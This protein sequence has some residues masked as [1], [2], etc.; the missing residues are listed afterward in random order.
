MMG[1]E[2]AV[3][4]CCFI[5]EDRFVLGV[6]FS[7]CLQTWD[8]ISVP[9]HVLFL[10]LL[11]LGRSTAPKPSYWETENTANRHTYE[12]ARAIS[13]W[14]VFFFIFLLELFRASLHSIPPGST[15]SVFTISL[16][17]WI[18]GMC[19]GHSHLKL[20]IMCRVLDPEF[21]LWP[22]YA[23]KLYGSLC[24]ILSAEKKTHLPT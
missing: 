1:A 16:N 22:C 20:S 3:E 7:V 8:C 9:L 19:P 18:W 24:F 14:Y 6:G 2:A 15:S 23:Y 17:I 11:A 13:E 12:V 4:E 21:S 10:L 5:W